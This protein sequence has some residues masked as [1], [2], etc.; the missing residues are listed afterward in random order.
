M[1]ARHRIY[2]EAAG[3]LFVGGLVG[4]GFA[5][6]AAPRSGKESRRRMAE[7]TEDLVG[8]AECYAGL[9]KEKV[10]SALKK[11]ER[12]FEE[13]KSIMKTAVEAGR[14]AYR[15]EI[16]RISEARACQTEKSGT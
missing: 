1:I 15:K 10:T 7:F 13:R 6:M 4:A 2:K 9:A 8:R 14:E 11:G 5:L 3:A 12:F 16:K